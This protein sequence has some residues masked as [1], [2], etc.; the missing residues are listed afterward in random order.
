MSQNLIFKMTI[1]TE[2]KDEILADGIVCDSAFNAEI[3]KIETSTA[4][5]EFSDCIDVTVTVSFKSPLTVING[6]PISIDLYST[7]SSSIDIPGTV[8]EVIAA[9]NIDDNPNRYWPYYF[10]H[11]CKTFIDGVEVPYLIFDNRLITYTRSYFGSNEHPFRV[12]RTWIFEIPEGVEE[13]CDEAFYNCDIM[14]H[15]VL[16][17]SLKKIGKRAFY[18]VYTKAMKMPRNLEFVDDEAFCKAGGSAK[19]ELNLPSIKWIGD[20]AFALNAPQGYVHAEIKKLKIGKNLEHIG[21]DPFGSIKIYEMDGKFVTEDSQCLVYEHKLLKMVS[22]QDPYN[23]PEE[24]SFSLPADV[25]EICS[26]AIQDRKIKNLMLPAGLKTIR[27]NGIYCRCECNIEIPQS[28]ELIEEDAFSYSCIIPSGKFVDS[29]LRAVIFGDMLISMY[30]DSD[31]SD[32]VVKIPEGIKFIGESGIICPNWW[33]CRKALYLPISLK[34][35]KNR[36]Q[37]E[38]IYYAGNLEG[39]LDIEQD[40]LLRCCEK[41]VID[42]EEIVD[43]KI[44]EGVEKIGN[45]FSNAKC[46]KT[47]VFPKSLKT[48]GDSAFP[49]SGL[50]KVEVPETVTKIG[51]Y[52]FWCDE[53]E[54]A[55]LRVP[56]TCFDKF[57]KTFREDTHIFVPKQYLE[58]YQK[59]S[60][61]H[62][63]HPI[64]I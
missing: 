54:E 7:K 11:N 50:T 3:E 6:N 58:D 40:E 25:E 55:I 18:G 2:R 51:S 24:E 4:T 64:N 49:F 21:A 29:E 1:P 61:K 13:I 12:T 32:V 59:A 19:W 26:Y 9:E 15:V 38:E 31:A 57:S 46:I 43:L 56:V 34:C 37:P 28:V 45:Q 36:L 5:S 60:D 52:A 47:V 35:M 23:I 30:I 27:T 17:K 44:P 14:Q 22:P 63:I 41:L 10:W 48:I 16:P 39:F 62:Q 42:N 20:R 53:M 8:K 33:C